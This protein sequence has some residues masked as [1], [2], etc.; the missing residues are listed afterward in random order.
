MI[1]LCFE[2]TF[3]CYVSC[4]PSLPSFL[5]PPL[6]L[7]IRLYLFHPSILSPSAIPSRTFLLSD[8]AAFLICPVFI[9]LPLLPL[10]LSRP[11]AIQDER[12][13]ISQYQVLL[14]RLPLINKAT[15]QALINHL[16]W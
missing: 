4:P 2:F 6:N 1:N 12:M 15:L 11:L 16:Y 13:K 8:A 14:N 3:H 9:I 5:I 7:S 10:P